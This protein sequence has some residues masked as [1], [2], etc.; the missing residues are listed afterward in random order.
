MDEPVSKPPKPHRGRATLLRSHMKSRIFIQWRLG[1]SLALPALWRL[2]G[3]LALPALWRLGGSLALPALWRLGGS[4]A[5]PVL[6]LLHGILLRAVVLRDFRGRTKRESFVG[7]RFPD[8]DLSL[9]SFVSLWFQSS[10]PAGLRSIA[11]RA[12]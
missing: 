10:C 5:L 8:R 7:Q 12:S 11:I 6:K 2:G 4:L 9:V 1:G 3:S